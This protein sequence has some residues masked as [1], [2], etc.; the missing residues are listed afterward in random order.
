[1]SG[2]LYQDDRTIFQINAIKCYTASKPRTEVIIKEVMQEQILE[3]END[4][5]YKKT[6]MPHQKN[7]FPAK[8]PESK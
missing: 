1:M 8:M 2:I 3:K 5:D 6:Q 4:K 7:I